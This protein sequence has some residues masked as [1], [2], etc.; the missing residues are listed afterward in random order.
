MGTGFNLKMGAGCM[1]E[2]YRGFSDSCNVYQFY[3]I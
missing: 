3:A 1:V 2:L